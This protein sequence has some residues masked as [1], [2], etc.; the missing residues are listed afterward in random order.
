MIK[1]QRVTNG[2]WSLFPQRLH[3]H[4]QEAN[5]GTGQV[6][7]C[8]IRRHQVFLFVQVSYPSFGSLFYYHLIKRR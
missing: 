3:S 4:P 6:P 2:L 5:L 8:E 1:P 7:T